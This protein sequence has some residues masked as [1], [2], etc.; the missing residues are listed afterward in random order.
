MVHPACE[1][2]ESPSAA[3][4]TRMGQSAAIEKSDCVLWAEV[5]L[6]SLATLE[7][8]CITSATAMIKPMLS[9]AQPRTGN[10]AIMRISKTRRMVFERA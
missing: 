8:R 3:A 7:E 4:D 5:R 10:K 1:T 6:D 2:D 9:A